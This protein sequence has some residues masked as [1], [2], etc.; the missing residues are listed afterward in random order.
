M[1]KTILTCIV[2]VTKVQP[3]LARISNLISEIAKFDKIA[4]ILVHD[5]QDDYSSLVLDQLLKDF[6]KE[7]ITYLVGTFGNPGDARNFALERV[8]TPWLFF[9]DG[10]DLIYPDKYLKVLAE[11]ISFGCDLAVSGI[12]ITSLKDQDVSRDHLINPRLS[13]QENLALLP[14]FTRIIYRSDF[15]QGVR[16]PS[17]AMAEDQCFLF[18]ILERKPK[19][20]VSNEI[21]YEYFIGNPSQ[22]SSSSAPMLDLR[23]SLLFFVRS[24]S[25]DNEKLFGAS[26]IFLIRQIYTFSSRLRFGSLPF[27]I[28]LAPRLFWLILSHPI[29]FSFSL[30]KV[31]FFSK[32]LVYGKR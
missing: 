21:V 1:K 10:D 29:H 3:Y 6:P 19:I 26:F 24:F 12:R 13:I 30:S 16:F 9:A 28:V 11:T 32:G 20:W 18:S 17:S 31:F 14:A 22:L 8:S 25:S 4:L 5:I 27:L 7:R 2:P 15:I 23:E